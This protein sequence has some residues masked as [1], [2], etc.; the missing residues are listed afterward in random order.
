MDQEI[1]NHENLEK[2]NFEG[3]RIFKN[4]I[5]LVRENR[6]LLQQNAAFNKK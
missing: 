6:P 2:Q 4:S 1:R 5:H 3:E